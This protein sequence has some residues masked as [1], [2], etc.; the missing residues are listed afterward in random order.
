[1][2]K[3]E[4]IESL[5]EQISIKENEIKK[6]NIK[7]GLHTLKITFN[8]RSIAMISGLNLVIENILEKDSKTTNK[9]KKQLTDSLNEAYNLN[10]NEIN[11][12]QFY[13]SLFLYNLVQNTETILVDFLK[14]IL[15]N[16]P[17]KIGDY[18]IS[19]KNLVNHSKEEVI[20]NVINEYL[21]KLMYESPK[22][23]FNKIFDIFS[24]NPIDNET[25]QKF[26][27]IKARRDIGIHNNWLTNSVYLKK[28]DR[29]FFKKEN[30]LA[31]PDEKYLE[32]AYDIM[33]T[34]ISYIHDELIKKYCT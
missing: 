17:G 21:N 10:T 24:I 29:L 1:M 9:L 30:V 25:I 23:Y 32:Y 15:I 11:L 3:I 22:E 33:N 8:N 12:E 7:I 20:E 26:I 16:Y 6:N 14:I 5:K 19:I 2:K 28:T 4:D 13:S 34:L 18:A 27:E 31:I